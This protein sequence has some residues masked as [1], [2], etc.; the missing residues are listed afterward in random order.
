MRDGH[1]M[2]RLAIANT[3]LSVWL[4]CAEASNDKRK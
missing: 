2:Q 1:A 3:V 4:K